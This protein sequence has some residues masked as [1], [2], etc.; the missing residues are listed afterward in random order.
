MAFAF[1]LILPVTGLVLV[2]AAIQARK[3]PSSRYRTIK[4]AWLFVVGVSFLLIGFL[5]A[6][7]LL[8]G[9]VSHA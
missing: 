5:A 1:A 7:A 3:Q 6:A 2:L 9:S 8:I 4:M